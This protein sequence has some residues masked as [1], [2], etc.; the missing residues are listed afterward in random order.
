MTGASTGRYRNE[1]TARAYCC[2]DVSSGTDV[3]FRGIPAILLEVVDSPDPI[4]VNGQTTYTIDVTNQGDADDTEISI[5]ATLAPEQKFISADGSGARGATHR[6][7]GQRVSFSTVPVIH[8]KERIT[9]KVTVSALSAANVRFAVKLTSKE[10][11]QGGSIDE[12][13]S[14]TQY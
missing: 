10:T 7:D 4:E 5:T 11:T 1:A 13:E 8:A 2:D 14:T 9:Y 6:V 3:S 12:T